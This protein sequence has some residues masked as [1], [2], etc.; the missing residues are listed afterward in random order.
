[1]H[2]LHLG[3]GN[4]ADLCLRLPDVRRFSETNLKYIKYFYSIYSQLFIIWPQV[5]D[6]L[7]EM[8]FSIPWGHHKVLIDKFKKAPEKGKA[9][10]NFSAVLPA[11]QS[12]LGKSVT[13]PTNKDDKTN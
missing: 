12:D 11:P 2:K 9:I 7:E 1:M 5:V 10:S 8:L 13:P 4:D 3:D 6:K